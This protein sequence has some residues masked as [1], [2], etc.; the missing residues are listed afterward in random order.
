MLL[1]CGSLDWDIRQI[2]ADLDAGHMTY[3]QLM[4]E[5]RPAKTIRACIDP[6]WNRLERYEEGVTALLHYTDMPT[7]PWVF[8]AHPFGHLWVRDLLE[9]IE[10]GVVARE[11]VEEHVERGWVRPTLLH[12][13]DKREPEAGRLPARLRA[14]DDAF[15][16]P[17]QQISGRKP[18][19]KR[20]A[21]LWR[22]LA[23]VFR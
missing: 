4:G 17:Y 18:R 7:Q 12:Q 3:Q 14:A 8:A 5:M 15:E 11:E 23:R 21:R 2:V 9:A 22:R 16:A 10:A 13:I 1:D 6:A 19:R 20:H